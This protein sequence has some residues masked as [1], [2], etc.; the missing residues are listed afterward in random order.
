MKIFI[1]TFC[2]HHTDRETILFFAHYFPVFMDIPY[3][4]SPE[5]ANRGLHMSSKSSI[6]GFKEKGY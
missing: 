1:L 3:L 6:P 2:S 5:P 4:L